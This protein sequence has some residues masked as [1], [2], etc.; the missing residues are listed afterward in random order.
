MT[1][2][3]AT[4]FAYLAIVFGLSGIRQARFVIDARIAPGF[5]GLASTAGFLVAALAAGIAAHRYT[6]TYLASI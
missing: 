2:V 5:V 1:L 3:L 6:I 4:L